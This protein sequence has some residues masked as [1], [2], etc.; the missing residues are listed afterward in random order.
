MY[1]NLLRPSGST[2]I[3]TTFNIKKFL[4]GAHIV[5][6]YFVQLSGKMANFALYTNRPVMYNQGREC[7]LCS[8]HLVCTY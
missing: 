7:L 2:L 1:I 3:T 5:F 8:M 6:V 4:H